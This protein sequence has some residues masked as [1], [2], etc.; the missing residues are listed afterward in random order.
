MKWL[1]M[2]TNTRMMVTLRTTIIMFKRADS[3]MPAIQMTEVSTTMNTA[4]KLTNPYA[5]E[6]SAK[7]TISNGEDANRAGKEMPSNFKIWTKVADQLT[8]TVAADTAYSSTKSQPMIHARY[9][10]IVAYA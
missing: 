2:T 4:G 6:P 5:N 1:P 10:P 7:V 9:S 3:R 8:D